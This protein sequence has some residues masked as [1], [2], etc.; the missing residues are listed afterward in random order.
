MMP[1][2]LRTACASSLVLVGIWAGFS[3][4]RS[5][6]RPPAGQVMR[7]SAGEASAP[8]PTDL[9]HEPAGGVQHSAKVPERLPAFKL[10]NLSGKITSIDDFAGKSL[11]LN[12]WATWCAPCQREMP[13]L[14]A[15][16]MEWASH[17]LEVVGIA[18]DYPDKVADFAK[19]LKIAYPLLVGEQDALDV[20]TSLGVQEPVFPFSVF[21]DR[22]GQIV[23]LFVGELHRPQAD[24]ILSVVQKLNTDSL[25]LPEARRLIAAGLAAQSS[26]EPMEATSESPT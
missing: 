22:R 25:R 1:G 10:A 14:Q 20:A 3:V 23:A 2:W 21:T 26:V 17:G 15:I 7:V 5:H 19:R 13:L 9:A 11:L 4:Y 12:F 24:L 16:N 18:V 8:N 6:F